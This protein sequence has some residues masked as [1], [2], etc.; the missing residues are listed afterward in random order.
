MSGT[1]QSR[2][3]EKKV[4]NGDENVYQ[5]DVPH[6]ELA[7]VPRGYVL[8]Y[9]QGDHVDKPVQIV[10]HSCYHYVGYVYYL[11]WGSG[12]IEELLQ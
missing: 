5:D 10:P 2:T 4:L 6:T 3:Y 9:P 7:L 1:S 12:I 8:P 11:R